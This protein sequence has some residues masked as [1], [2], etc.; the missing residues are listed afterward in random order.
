MRW[1]DGLGARGG[2]RVFRY[3]WPAIAAAGKPAALIAGEDFEGD[4]EKPRQAAYAWAVTHGYR[5]KT[6]VDHRHAEVRVFFYRSVAELEACGEPWRKLWPLSHP[7]SWIEQWAA[8][9]GHSRRLSRARDRHYAGKWAAANGFTFTE[10]GESV[11]TLTPIKR[12][13]FSVRVSA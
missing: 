7:P 3:P 10:H 13:A 4:L 8:S 9:G 6:S 2:S 1:V 11:C 5:V 12:S